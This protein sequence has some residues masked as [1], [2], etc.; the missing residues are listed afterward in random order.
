MKNE[1][2][3]VDIDALS[4]LAMLSLSEGKREGLLFDME[5]IVAFARRVSEAPV[6]SG[7]VGAVCENVF[8]EDC[9][10]ARDGGGD[11]LSTAPEGAVREGFFT[12]PKVVE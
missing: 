7:D 1:K 10:S 5:R 9:E 3:K 2:I 4:D 12:V 8:R 6:S 11:L